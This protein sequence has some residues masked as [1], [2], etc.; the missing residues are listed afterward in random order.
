M[1]SSQTQSTMTVTGIETKLGNRVLM[2]LLQAGWVLEYAYPDSS[3]DKGIDFDAYKIAR[4]D[5][6][7]AFEW[8][9]WEEWQISGPRSVLEAICGEYGW[10]RPFQDK[11]IAKPA[12]PADKVECFEDL[13]AVHSRG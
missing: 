12:S 7:L 8:T 6:R 1:D 13:H 5:A 2:E 3:I 4:D 10:S 11:V 9:N